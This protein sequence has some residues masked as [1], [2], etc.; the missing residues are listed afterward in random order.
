MIVE[1]IFFLSTDQLADKLAANAI[2]SDL[3]N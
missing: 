3:A 1:T 2:I